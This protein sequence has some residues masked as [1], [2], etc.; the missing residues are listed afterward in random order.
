MLLAIS[1]AQVEMEWLSN[2]H[3][4]VEMKTAIKRK[5]SD[6]RKSLVVGLTMS[7][8]MALSACQTSEAGAIMA[9]EDEGASH[10]QIT[11]KIVGGIVISVKKTPG[12]PN[13]SLRIRETMVAKDGGP[14][15]DAPTGRI[16]NVVSVAGIFAEDPNRLRSA[17]IVM[18]APS[19]PTPRDLK[20]GECVSVAPD[21]IDR[22][23]T[24]VRSRI[25]IEPSVRTAS[26]RDVFQKGVVELWA[27]TFPPKSAVSLP[28]GGGSHSRNVASEPHVNAKNVPSLR[29]PA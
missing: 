14:V 2:C 20:V 13:M 26:T 21:D 3:A 27:V 23:Q 5:M 28:W 7:V 4:G 12:S 25:E 29:Q 1:L 15:C 19:D 18:E 8:G 22:V 24:A 17:M 10:R 11:K 9:I 6:W 16:L